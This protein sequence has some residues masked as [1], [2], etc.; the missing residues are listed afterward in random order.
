LSGLGFESGGLAA[1]HGFAQSFTALPLTNAKH[2]HGEMVAMGTLA[3]LV[4]E[5]RDDEARR[6]ARF[7]AQ[8]GLPVHLGQLR[9]DAGDTS[10]LD[11]IA[12]GALGFPFI[13]NMPMQIDA[14]VLRQGLLGAHD[15]GLA[16]CKQAG[17]ASYRRLHGP[18]RN[19]SFVH[20][21]AL[22]PYSA[23]PVRLEQRMP[24]STSHNRAAAD[25]HL[26][27]ETPCFGEVARRA[28]RVFAQR[29]SPA[30]SRRSKPSQRP[31]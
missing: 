21:S 30:R 20:S 1:A 16:V 6:V 7:F 31:G 29:A 19:S 9:I 5:S 13:G 12:A 10:A 15:L 17:D 3:Q 26:R 2:L 22:R 18:L 23:S 8:V 25:A 27:E 11:T 24:R 28:V 14:A 4:L